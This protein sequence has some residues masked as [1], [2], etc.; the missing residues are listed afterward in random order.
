M[1]IFILLRLLT[2]ECDRFLLP[3]R[4]SALSLLSRALAWENDS[5]GLKVNTR[6][7]AKCDA[8]QKLQRYITT[9]VVL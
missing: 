3:R 4:K 5:A 9:C 2:S 8:T 7:E 6:I 1:Q